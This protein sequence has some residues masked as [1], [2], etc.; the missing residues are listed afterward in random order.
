MMI[1]TE[2]ARGLEL[3]DVG[4]CNGE[5]TTGARDGFG[6]EEAR[7]RRGGRR[8]RIAAEG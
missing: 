7:G 1:H 8:R 5:E 2:A 3:G 6:A 4:G